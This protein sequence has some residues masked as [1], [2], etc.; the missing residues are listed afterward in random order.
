MDNNIISVLIEMFNDKSTFTNIPAA[1]IEPIPNEFL[2]SLMRYGMF[3]NVA[4]QINRIP[5]VNIWSKLNE[6]ETNFRKIITGDPITPQ[7][8]GV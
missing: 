6:M 5:D 2:S 1:Y 3:S 8:H 7:N 4:V